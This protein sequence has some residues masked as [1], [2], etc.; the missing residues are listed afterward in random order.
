LGVGLSCLSAMLLVG[1]YLF[2]V[3]AGWH[4]LIVPVLWEG[5]IGQGAEECAVC[6]CLSESHVRLTY[7]CCGL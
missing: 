2:S 6:V 5:A 7:S 3:H 4:C 1:V